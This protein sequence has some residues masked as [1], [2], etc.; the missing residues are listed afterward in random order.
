[1]EG[2]KKL[3]SAL[4]A[5]ITVLPA[6]AG[7]IALFALNFAIIALAMV[8][9]SAGLLCAP[10]G[11]LY[12]MGFI[13]VISDL[14]PTAFMAAGF[15]FLSFGCFLSLCVLKLAPFSTRLFY[16]YCYRLAGKRWRR[17]YTNF[18]ITRFLILSLVLSVLSFGAMLTAQAVSVKGGFESTV[19]R[20]RLVFNDAKYIYVS[21]S[22]LDFEIKRHSGQGIMLDYVND[23]GIIAEESDENYLRLV[24]DDSFAVSLFAKDQFSYKM[25]LWLP[26]ND[27]REFYLDSGSGDITL[28]ETAAL[29]TEVRTRSGTIRINDAD[30][31]IKAT[32]AAGDIYCAYCEFTEPASFESKSGDIKITMP[33]YSGVKLKYRT[34]GGA[35]LGD[36]MGQPEDFIGSVDLE[37]P[38][39]TTSELYVTTT[40][41]SL[42]V[43]KTKPQKEN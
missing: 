15:F 33:E 17:I 16:G 1:M 43:D 22:S 23:S 11:G 4:I 30:K 28:F 34:E 29:Y 12:T 24:Q 25:T 20:E 19:I 9:I 32:T 13:K 21:T 40:S 6:L 8:L 7:F 18:K 36:L 37:K 10:L 26:E 38:A 14:S 35:L 42:T 39:S 2:G 41:G 5:R 31:Q 27:Y 3:N